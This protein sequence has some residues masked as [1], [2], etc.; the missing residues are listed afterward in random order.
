[1]LRLMLDS[2]PEISNPGEFD[3]L[4]DQLGSDGRTP[5]MRDYRRW[6]ATHRGFQSMGLAVD[7]A[8]GYLELMHSFIEQ[9]WR[10]DKVLTLN[11]HRHFDRLAALFPQARYIH[12]VRDPRD[13]ARS[14]IGMGW[15]GNTYRGVDIWAAAERSW[16]RLVP[17]LTAERYLQVHYEELL[18]RLTGELT[19]I[20]AFLG[21][22]Y[23][24]QMLHY[25]SRSTYAAPDSRLMY[26]W[27]RNCGTRELQWIDWKLGSMLVQRKYQLS[28]FGAQQPSLVERARIA[29]QDKLYRIRFR[30]A[31]YGLALYLENL[32]ASRAHL[33]SWRDS[34]QLR[35]N[36]IDVKFLK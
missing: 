24:P 31:R 35:M 18:A 28:G 19:R 5:H 13:V 6:L 22:G 12:L 2:H 30:I 1:M 8:L 23:S 11:V 14:S 10:N 4:V 32:L 36:E 7:P 27:K 15:A 33:P 26:Q 25:N 17:S 34:C 9:L 3:F 16:D 29:L 21:R 20:C